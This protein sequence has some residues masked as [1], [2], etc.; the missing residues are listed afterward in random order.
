MQPK[1]SVTVEVEN[2]LAKALEM[3]PKELAQREKQLVLYK[4]NHHVFLPY[5]TK[6]QTTKVTLS[7]REN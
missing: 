4:G 1:D 6:T 5:K 7:G 3:F 2:V